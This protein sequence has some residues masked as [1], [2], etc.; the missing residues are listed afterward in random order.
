GNLA[1]G[2][3]PA[4]GVYLRDLCA[5]PPTTSL[6]SLGEDGAPLEEATFAGSSVDGDR[7]LV[8][9][10]PPEPRHLFLRDLFT[11]AT[12]LIDRADGS[13]GEPGDGEVAWAALS[14]DGCR[15]AFTSAAADLTPQEP[16]SGGGNL[17]QAYA[18]QLDGCRPPQ[19]PGLGPGDPGSG[20]GAG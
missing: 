17:L 19:P 8:M 2:P 15:A 10:A 5:T 6:I 1:A 7:V 3:A 18:R 20:S 13:A 16:P 4:L 14:G 11:G 9:G 12:R